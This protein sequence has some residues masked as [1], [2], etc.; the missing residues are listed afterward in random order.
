M[1]NQIL[2]SFEIE[3]IKENS[4]KGNLSEAFEHLK[5]NAETILH[6][7]RLYGTICLDVDGYPTVVNNRWF[8]DDK[9]LQLRFEIEDEGQPIELDVSKLPSNNYDETGD[10]L[11][12]YELS[13]YCMEVLI[14]KRKKA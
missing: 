13:P 7:F 4:K 9:A 6:V 10:W 3:C 11:Y 14:G 12:T 1:L 2:T 5:E 8:K